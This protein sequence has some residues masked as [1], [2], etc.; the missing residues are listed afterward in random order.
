VKRLL[1]LAFLL[2]LVLATLGVA[3]S[4]LA[5]GCKGH[6]IIALIAE[7][8]LTPRARSMVSQILSASPISTSLSRYCRESGLDPFVDSSTW[9][10]DIRSVR[11]NTAPWHF[12]DIPRGARR[13]NLARYCRPADSCLTSALAAQLRVL[14]NP[15]A[16]ATD[17]AD[18]LRFIIHLVGDLHQP[19]HAVTNN[20]RGG[21]CVPVSFFGRSPQQTDPI[22]E[23]YSP[24]L[25][26]VWDV[27]I[28]ERSSRSETPQQLA[29]ALERKF[30][31]AKSAWKTQRPDFAAWAWETHALAN[32]V[33]YGRL[34]REIPIEPP[35]DVATCAD[36]NHISSRMLRLHEDL[37]PRY[38]SA[39]APVVDEQLVK[40]GVR[41]AALLNS[42]WR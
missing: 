34:S 25:H 39:A 38:Q 5:W 28:V 16:A 9:A 18:A 17:R 33:A 24:N 21:N 4:A 1:R 36:D 23:N 10:D 8:H 37:G 15:R 2:P 29:R 19:M 30:R 22:R 11:P 12:I 7:A 27:E 42:L 6:Q 40:A 35:R 14:Q 32:T 20:D 13:G 3:P 31:G 26:E 41:L